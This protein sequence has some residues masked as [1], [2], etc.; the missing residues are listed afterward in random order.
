MTPEEATKTPPWD[1]RG[2]MEERIG[3]RWTSV[4]SGPP[5]RARQLQ[6]GLIDVRFQDFV[7]CFLRGHQGLFRLLLAG[8]HRLHLI[9]KRLA[10]GHGLVGSE[11]RLGD[12]ELIH[13]DLGIGI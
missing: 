8:K 6:R 3:I 13:A 11:P 7:G 5:S 10:H 12:R 1:L 9:L 2:W 4:P